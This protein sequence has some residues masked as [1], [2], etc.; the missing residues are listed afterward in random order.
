MTAT[1]LYFE[2]T[3]KGECRWLVKCPKFGHLTAEYTCSRCDY[4]V[5]ISAEFVKCKYEQERPMTAEEI[6]HEEKRNNP[7]NVK[8][9]ERIKQ[10][11]EQG[12]EFDEIA[13]TLHSEG[14][15]TNRGNKR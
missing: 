12:C 10:L 3:I 9:Y 4:C 1:K 15:V 13:R 6:A 5:L 8:S 7:L 2:T 14:F 11:Q